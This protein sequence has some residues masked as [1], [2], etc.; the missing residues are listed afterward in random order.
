MRYIS[1]EKVLVHAHLTARR[2]VKPLDTPLTSTISGD[3]GSHRLGTDAAS[4]TIPKQKTAGCLSASRPSL[5][6]FT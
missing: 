2:V 3:K 6:S 1:P 5:S 4:G